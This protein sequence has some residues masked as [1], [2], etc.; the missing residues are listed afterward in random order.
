MWIQ[1]MN[2]IPLVVGKKLLD[3]DIEA[4]VIYNIDYVGPDYFTIKSEAVLNANVETKIPEGQQT[5]KKIS[6][7]KIMELNFKFEIDDTK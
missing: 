1:L 4:G 2:T 3:G 7:M 5:P 6:F